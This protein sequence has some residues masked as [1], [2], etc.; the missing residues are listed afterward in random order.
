MEIKTIIKNFPINKN[1][2]KDGFTGEFYQKFG[3][4]LTPILLKLLQKIAE[5]GKLPNSFY[6]ATI[7]LIPK[8]NLPQKR[9]LQANITDEHRCKNPQQNSSKQNPT[10]Y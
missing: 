5:E 1:S 7:M 2:G 3:E 10:T 6:E 9:K 4:E 8:P